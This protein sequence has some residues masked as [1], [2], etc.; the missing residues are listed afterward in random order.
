[1]SAGVSNI[2][3]SLVDSLSLSCFFV[4]DEYNA[5]ASDGRKPDRLQRKCRKFNRTLSQ[6][7]VLVEHVIGEVKCYKVIGTLWRLPRTKLKR[8]AEICAGL[9]CRRRQLNKTKLTIFF[10]VSILRRPPHIIL[11]LS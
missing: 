4:A 5:L 11:S 9:V 2:L 8:V 10:S 3:P 7:R 6:Y 1:L